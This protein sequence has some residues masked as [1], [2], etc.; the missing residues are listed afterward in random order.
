MSLAIKA[1]TETVNKAGM[2]FGIEAQRIKY[3]I[4]PYLNFKQAQNFTMAYMVIA[5]T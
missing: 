5:E 4:T 1:S 3:S 2:Y